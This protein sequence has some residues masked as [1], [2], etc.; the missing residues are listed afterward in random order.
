MKAGLSKGRTATRRGVKSTA[1]RL[2]VVV[3]REDDG[4][5]SVYVPDLPGCASWGSSHQEALTNIREAVQ[6]YLEGLQA[7]GQPIPE[8]RATIETIRVA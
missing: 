1:R 3:E 7:D 2:T 8:P 5:Y 4:R 6:C